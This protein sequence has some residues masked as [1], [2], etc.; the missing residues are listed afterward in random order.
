[1]TT[2]SPLSSLSQPSLSQRTA[3][4]AIGALLAALSPSFAPAQSIAPDASVGGQRA[5][6]IT[7]DDA[8]TRYY[9]A[10]TGADAVLLIHGARPGGTSSANTWTPIIALPGAGAGSSRPWHDRQS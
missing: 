10:G 3:A 8:R 6:F 5:Q 4:V 9:E 1:M 7:I 2:R